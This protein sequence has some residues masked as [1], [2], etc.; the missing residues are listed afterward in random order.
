MSAVRPRIVDRPAIVATETIKSR[1]GRDPGGT[2]WRVSLRRLR[3]FTLVEL[4][5]AMT[6]TLLLMAALGK[7]FAVIG[8]TM[9]EGRA[10]V[11]LSSKLRGISFRLRT[12]LRS[13]TV[14]AQ[15]PLPSESGS[16]YLMVYEG[17]L[18]ETTFAT[19][20]GEPTRETSDGSVLTEATAAALQWNNVDI[21]ATFRGLSRF[22]DF[23]DYIAFTAEAPADDW[24]TGKVPAY[25]V[26]DTAVD[27]MEP[28]VIRSKYAEIIIWAS[29]EWD[30][31]P[32]T[33]GLV[34][35]RP[36]GGP[37]PAIYPDRGVPLYR[38]VDSDFAPDRIVLH[39]RTLLIRP[40]LNLERTVLTGFNAF[41]TEVIRPLNNSLNP[42]AVPERLRRL[43]PIGQTNTF[44]TAPPAPMFP[45]YV[46][47]GSNTNNSRMLNSNWLVGMTPL[48]HF[49]DLSLR[50]IF[51]PQTG[52]P[53]GYVACNSLKDLTSPHNRFAH[54]RYPGRY[55]GRGDF[56]NSSSAR[57]EVT[58]MPLLATGWNDALLDWQAAQD[59]RAV[60]A[61]AT[62]PAWFPV[63]RQRS[64][65]TLNSA[66]GATPRHGLFNGWLLPH[67]EL[68]DP[69]PAAVG[70][71]DRW[72]RGYL[73]D[74]DVRWDR[75]GEDVISSNILAL[76]IKGYDPNAPVFL[77]PGPDQRPGRAGVNDDG[78]GTDPDDVFYQAPT[79]T[80]IEL[81][82]VGSDDVLVGVGDIGIYPLMIRR[83]IDPETN[84]ANFTS[85]P[86]PDPAPDEVLYALAGRGDFVDLFYPFLPGTPLLNRMGQTNFNTT[87]PLTDTVVANV[88]VNYN[89]F[90]QSDL[91][92]LQIPWTTLSPIKRSGKL[93]H[94][95]NSGAIVFF[96]PTFDT[97]TDIYESD[98]FDQT[99]SL[100]GTV[101]P[102][103]TNADPNNGTVWVLNN[104]T[105]VAKD[106]R[107]PA[108]PNQFQIDSSRY[109]PDQTETSPPLPVD[110]STIQIT[111][112][113]EDP[114][115]HEMIQ[116]TIVEGLQ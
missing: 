15:P 6:I 21:S 41:S 61:L 108:T 55:F 110:L 50:R 90:L 26:D 40:D 97:W 11:S 57:D 89:Q 25:L 14:H 38:D 23:D 52:D 19:F 9:K 58:S 100:A 82:A 91:S 74:Q 76:D 94:S 115:S 105:A 44:G 24:F 85:P 87:P 22:G 88:N 63:G 18:T 92:G 69:N 48:H 64:S 112:R 34:T 62:P 45:D 59:T 77:T 8:K 114:E 46:D 20:G 10:Q 116:F 101:L 111:V 72:Q 109:D 31:D 49:Y 66:N 35:N 39:Q 2:R 5:I 53:T 33:N 103:G 47:L 51:H 12:D 102:A 4:M 73:A 86:L 54:V 106:P 81:G 80:S 27:P 37:R 28:R 43:Y 68:G 113:A 98:G 83:I 1:R 29:P 71:I 65:L 104:L 16:G 42:D 70:T 30:V 79:G 13:R 36:A 96:Q 84:T 7:S 93:V 3:G 67:F 78:R 95:N 99:S 75:T 107:L 60:P 32:T 17:P 56:T